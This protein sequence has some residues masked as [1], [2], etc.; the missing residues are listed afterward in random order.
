MGRHPSGL[1]LATVLFFIEHLSVLPA[2]TFAK[3]HRS[4]LLHQAQRIRNQPRSSD[5]IDAMPTSKDD[6]QPLTNEQAV[7]LRRDLTLVEERLQDIAIL[8]RICY[9]DDSHAVFRADE[10]A[11]AL[12]RLKW[13]LERTKSRAQAAGS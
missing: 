10:T 2:V 8:M 12:Q 11:A 6:L 7:Q 13:E 1:P 4:Q 5:I 3:E 9:G